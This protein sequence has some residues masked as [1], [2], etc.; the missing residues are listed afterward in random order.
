MPMAATATPVMSTRV[1]LD[2]MIVILLYGLQL[3]AR[4]C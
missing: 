4:L 3:S 1:F 2:L